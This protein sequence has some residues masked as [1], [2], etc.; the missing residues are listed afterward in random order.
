[1]KTTCKSCLIVGLFLLLGSELMTGQTA[2]G[3]VVVANVANPAATAT[4][5]GQSSR[6]IAT[7]DSVA[8]LKT[9][10]EGASDALTLVTAICKDTAYVSSSVHPGLFDDLGT[11]E[12]AA[13]AVLRDDGKDPITTTRLVNAFVNAIN[14]NIARTNNLRNQATETPE[15]KDKSQ[16]LQKQLTA[17]RTSFQ[18]NP[19]A[20]TGAS[21]PIASA[22]GATTTGNPADG[23]IILPRPLAAGGTVARLNSTSNSPGGINPKTTTSRLKLSAKRIKKGAS[24]TWKIQSRQSWWIH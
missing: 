24:V 14:Q 20:K 2:T 11:L 3:T 9:P 6:A 17:I 15:T 10:K 4:S 21:A 18:P 5:P 8:K 1:M 16:H 7:G 13:S 23:S 12:G 22:V 19:L